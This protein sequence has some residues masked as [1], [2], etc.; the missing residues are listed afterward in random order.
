MTAASYDQLPYKTYPQRESNPSRLAAIARILGIDAPSV[1]ASS[2]LEIGCGTGG[3][4]IPLAERFPESRFVGFDLSARH[5]DE[6]RCTAEQLGFSH[7]SFQQADLS[8]FEYR[9]GQ[10]DYIICHGVYSWVPI[11]VQKKIL[12][13]VQRLLSP[14]GVAYVSYN[15]FPGWYQRGVVRDVL[16][17]GAA[18]DSSSNVEERVGKA[19]KFLGVVASTRSSDGDLYGHY[20]RE[21]SERLQQSDVSYIAHEY[22]EES[23]NPCTFSDFNAQ[24]Q[25][26]GMQFLSESRPVFSSTNDLAPQVQALMTQLGEDVVRREQALDIFRNR[27]FRETLLCHSH[28]VIKRDLRASALRSVSAVSDYVRV[29]TAA[30]QGVS[31]REILSGRDIVLPTGLHTEVLNAVAARCAAGIEVE[32]VLGQIESPEREVLAALAMLWS[33]GFIH[34]EQLPVPAALS[35]DQSARVSRVAQMQLARGEPLCTLRHQALAVNT[36]EE[37]LLQGLDGSRTFAEIITAHADPDGVR[38]LLTAMIERG[39]FTS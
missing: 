8:D 37:A 31:F 30:T 4:L 18:L 13:L 34:F 3:N 24:A 35:L 20:L 21:A 28:H 14:N 29:N 9:E 2:V 1:K 36:A 26:Y 15:V 22:L 27:A 5:I 7:I 32:Q 38:A 17:F 39:V 19:L 12:G 10:F 11:D 25:S 6:A 23:N 16:S 33:S